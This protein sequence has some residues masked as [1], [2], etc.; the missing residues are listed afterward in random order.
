MF[1]RFSF[2]LCAARDALLELRG[3]ARGGPLRC[4]VGHETLGPATPGAVGHGRVT[5]GARPAVS[6][7]FPRE[8]IMSVHVNL[9]LVPQPLV[10]LAMAT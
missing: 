2:F 8:C 1:S 5:P 10:R 6:L 7:H 4:A 9:A 3:A